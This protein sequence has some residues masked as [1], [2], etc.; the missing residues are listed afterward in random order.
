M[1]SADLVQT[2]ADNIVKHRYFHDRF[3]TYLKEKNIHQK[4]W[5]LIIAHINKTNYEET[6]NLVHYLVDDN[7]DEI[8]DDEDNFIILLETLAG[9]GYDPNQIHYMIINLNFKLEKLFSI[10]KKMVSSHEKTVRISSGTV[11][12]LLGRKSPEILFEEINRNL[13]SNEDD[14]KKALLTGL[15]MA[16]YKP[17]RNPK[18]VLP[19]FVFQYVIENLPSSVNDI[20]FLAV[21]VSIRLFDL[22]PRFYQAL[23]A[24]I[25]E[26][27]AYKTN[28]LQAIHYET[29]VSNPESE[30][31]LLINCSKA[32]SPQIISQVLAIFADKLYDKKINRKELQRGALELIKRW[33]IHPDFQLL[34][35][36]TW[37]LENIAKA[38]TNCAFDF[39]LDWII[40]EQDDLIAHEFFYPKLIYNVFK[41]HE[42]HLIA[43]VER[44]VACDKRFDKLVDGI[45]HEIIFD[46]RTGFDSQ[47]RLHNETTGRDLRIYLSGHG[48]VEQLDM[49]CAEQLDDVPIRVSK[50]LEIIEEYPLPA[51]DSNYNSIEHKRKELNNTLEFFE[52]KTLLLSKCLGL[53][54]VLSQK[55]NLNHL[56]LTRNFKSKKIPA[57]MTSCEILRT[58]VFN[59]NR[60]EIDYSKIKDRLAFF[61]NI[62]KF[63]GYEWLDKKFKEGYPFHWILFWLSKSRLQ[64]ELD[65]MVLDYDKETDLIQKEIRRQDLRPNLT[66][67]G[68]LIHIDKSL[69]YFNQ[70]NHQG[71]KEIISGLRTDDNFLQFLSQLEM[72]NKL[73]RHGFDVRLE[74]PSINN[75]RIDIIASKNGVIIICEL[76]TLEMYNELKYSSFSSNIPD[77][78]KSLMLN[79]L[80]KQVSD[81]AKDRPGKPI[82]LM[83]NMSSAVDADLHGIQYA[84]QGTKVDNIIANRGTEVGRYI[85]F[86][87]DPEFLKIEEGRKLTGVVYY[88]N[89][90][91]GLNKCLNGNII[92][93]AT[94]EVKL[95]DQIISELKEALFE[96]PN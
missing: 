58:E 9:N 66:S 54:A 47:F 30:L 38:D 64:Q 3:K 12:G 5:P 15:I 63:F 82:L 13:D 8:V 1:S 31:S 88:T 35:G 59:K 91:V 46:L 75:R 94:A 45:F 95:E 29:L 92:L 49:L 74:V 53:L 18:F 14:K 21:F 78:P 34:S 90:F 76:A 42:D 23:E 52:R 89:E 6:K 69:N 41:S 80:A 25:S 73:Q 85:T 43:F 27:E 81:Y 10:Y 57:V 72:A 83:F 16:S 33:H 2:T 96:R 28:F 70:G 51:T 19:E 55:R 50:A 67:V 48:I 36:S 93:N 61:P 87:R 71:R 44:L 37:L 11:L 32:E 84:L 39:L 79:K 62:E 22:D 56:K 65:Q 24:Y 20:S 68:W 7:I 26:S 40:N 86:E 60:L 4:F 17:Y 77:R